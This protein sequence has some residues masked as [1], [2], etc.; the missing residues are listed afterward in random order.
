MRNS[1]FPARVLSKDETF[2]LQKISCADES[3][4]AEL[5]K[6]AGL[7]PLRDFRFADLRDLDFSLSDLRGYD[8][9]GA[10][11]TGVV[12]V[13]A[14]VD[15]TTILTDA[16]V[17]DSIF[18][19]RVRLGQLFKSNDR[20]RAIFEMVS[21]QDWAGQ[22]LWSGKNLVESKSNL[23]VIIPVTEALFYRAK[24]GFLKAE[25]LSHLTS[26]LKSTRTTKELLIRI[27]SEFSDSTTVVRKCLH[28]V[29][30]AK[31]SQDKTIRRSMTS[32]V[33]ANLEKW[34]LEPLR[35]LIKTSK[36]GSELFHLSRIAI[37][38]GKA[39]VYVRE[40]AVRLGEEYDLITR[41]PITNE[42]FQASVS[43][44]PSMRDLIARR[45]ARADAERQAYGGSRP[46]VELK[47]GF[48]A[49]D[50]E[51]S[52]KRV[53]VIER[54]WSDMKNYGINISVEQSNAPA[55]FTAN[56]PEGDSEMAPQTVGIA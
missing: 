44:K 50:D 55:L 11:L 38:Q 7:D 12:G 9:T 22:I 30:K 8:F 32:L 20:A 40:I 53:R 4:F 19:S 25:L 31:L 41:D 18:S 23:D 16:S 21:R 10:D 47:S 51:D 3:T 6:I 43:L 13:D 36:D 15:E 45:W 56:A 27:L 29:R 34:N 1:V 14:I 33:E 54:M 49:T 17:D 5:V 39:S 42:T 24:D 35:F 28:L 26:S 2:S 37:R 46:L 48:T 52:V